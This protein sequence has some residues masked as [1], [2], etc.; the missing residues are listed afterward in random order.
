VERAIE[1][2]DVEMAP[3]SHG[4]GRVAG[5]GGPA[6]QPLGTRSISLDN[7]RRRSSRPRALASGNVAVVI[8]LL[9]RRIAEGLPADASDAP[10]EVEES[11]LDPVELAAR[12]APPPAVDGHAL[13]KACHRKVKRL[14]RRMVERVDHVMSGGQGAVRASIQLAA[15]LGVLRW[16][17]R[18]EPE[19]A[20][21]PFRETLVPA[22]AADDLFWRAGIAVGLARPSLVE[23]AQAE[24]PDGCSEL[25]LA[26]GLLGWLALV[27]RI[28]L[29]RPGRGLS[30][31]TEEEPDEDD[32]GWYARSSILA[33]VLQVL[34]DAP[35]DALFRDAVRESRIRGRHEWLNA[36]VKLAAAAALVAA[37][38]ESAPTLP[39][40]ARRG[41][42]VRIAMPSGT[43]SVGYV[44][45]IEDNKAKVADAEHDGGRPVLQTF[46]APID[47]VA[48]GAG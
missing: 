28:D 26:V 37:E 11:E 17:Q 30:D 39:R 9:I 18:I 16:L 23:L 13:V 47:L 45:G 4:T 7:V 46:V 25:D 12:D 3:S 31:A 42:W 22:D 14:A 43:I 48:L 33:G 32:E 38:P 15:V 35:D 19:L 41:D 40:A 36:H 5:G 29:R 1:E 27:A 20:W 6:N 8:D 44:E 34:G 24:S 10:R 2:V 21:L